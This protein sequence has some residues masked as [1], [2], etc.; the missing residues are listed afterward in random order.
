MLLI[1]SPYK[2]RMLP[3]V[4]LTIGNASI[5]LSPCAKNLNSVFDQQMDFEALTSSPSASHVISTCQGLATSGGI[6]Q[7]TLQNNSSIHSWHQGWT[8]GTP[9]CLAFLTSSS[10]DSNSNCALLSLPDVIGVVFPIAR[11]VHMRL[12][13]LLS[14]SCAQLAMKL[15]ECLLSLGNV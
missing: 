2:C 6:S 10:I 11:W 9:C 14:R 4:N 15:N 12:A 5:V 13:G 1:A 3:P 7:N 8:T